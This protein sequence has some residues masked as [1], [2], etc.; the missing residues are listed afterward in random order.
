VNALWEPKAAKGLPRMS[1]GKVREALGRAYAREAGYLLI[2]EISV[3]GHSTRRT[4]AIA[5]QMYRSRGIGIHGF[6]IKVERRDWLNELKDAGK[7]DEVFARCQTFSLVTPQWLVDP[8]TLPPQWGLLEV[9][10]ADGKVLRTLE[11]AKLEPQ[12]LDLY[13]VSLILRRAYDF[14]AQ[15]WNEAHHNE[16]ARRYEEGLEAGKKYAVG[17]DEAAKELGRLKARIAAFQEA[18]GIDLDDSDYRSPFAGHS[19]ADIG[20][21]LAFALKAWE[22]V[23]GSRQWVREIGQDLLKLAGEKL[24]N[25]RELRGIGRR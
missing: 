10:H 15:P 11:P 17:G 6:E 24:P 20:A 19:P 16:L 7:A 12:P 22:K 23:D 8:A 9:R 5:L 1:A 3:P 2:H 13:S 25:E 18:S 21:A 4:D 14:M